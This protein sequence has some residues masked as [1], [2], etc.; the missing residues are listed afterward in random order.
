ML[1][2]RI[3]GGVKL[4]RGSIQANSHLLIRDLVLQNL[5]VGLLPEGLV[6]A[7]DSG[8]NAQPLNTIEPHAPLCLSLEFPSRADILPRVR[9]FADYFIDH[10]RATA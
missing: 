6:E 10:F 5:G 7:I 9:L 4:P 1:E 3:L 8:E 2:K